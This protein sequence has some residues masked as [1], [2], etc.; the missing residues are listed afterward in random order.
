MTKGFV[1]DV[2]E[3]KFNL[4]E[5][6]VCKA[7]KKE[8]GNRIWMTKIKTNEWMNRIKNKFGEAR[9]LEELK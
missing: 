8:K 6:V 1:N 9:Y 2:K 7:T 3:N 4:V 5:G